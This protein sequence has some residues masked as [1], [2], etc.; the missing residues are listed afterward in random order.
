M[1]G[2]A[3][4]NPV[5]SPSQLQHV[6][7]QAGGADAGRGLELADWHDRLLDLAQVP[8]L[9]LELVENGEAVADATRHG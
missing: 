7:L 4:A 2:G 8:H 3:V 9:V 1:R 5:I 6:S